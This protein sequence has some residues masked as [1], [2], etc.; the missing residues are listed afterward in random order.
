MSV[1]LRRESDRN[2]GNNMAVYQA[3]IVVRTPADGGSDPGPGG[4]EPTLPITGAP[5]GPLGIAGLALLLAGTGN[6][7]LTRRRR[8]TA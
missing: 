1:H 8:R 6:L 5:A 3:K 2:P 4:A 7:L